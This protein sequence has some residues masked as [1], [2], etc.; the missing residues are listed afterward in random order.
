MEFVINTP[1]SLV[2]QS[3]TFSD[4][5][6]HNTVKCLIGIAPH[7]H[8]TFV[9]PVFEGSASDRQ[10]VE[11]SGLLELLERG[12]SIMAGKGFKIQDLCAGIGVKVNIPPLRQGDRQMMP[13]DVATT[14]KIASVQIHVERKM[15]L[16]KC[17]AILSGELSNAMFDIIGQIILV[18]AMLTNFQGALVA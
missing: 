1:D 16:I 14:K 9:S 7:G 15:Q 18:C 2:R 5:K 11:E 4:Y 17:F 8:V 13:S 10:I 3:A 12:D 6:S